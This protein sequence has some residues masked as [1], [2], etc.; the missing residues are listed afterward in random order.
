MDHTSGA[1]QTAILRNAIRGYIDDLITNSHIWLAGYW[2]VPDDQNM[3]VVRKLTSIVCSTCQYPSSQNHGLVI[4]FQIPCTSSAAADAQIA[5]VN[6]PTKVLTCL[7]GPTPSRSIAVWVRFAFW[8]SSGALGSHSTVI[9]FDTKKML[10]IV[11]DPYWLVEEPGNYT[12]ALC[13]RQFH[14]AYRNCSVAECSESTTTQCIQSRLEANVHIDE[15]GLCSCL[16]FV[17]LLCCFR[18]HYFN[19]KH[20]AHIIAD[21]IDHQGRHFK[22]NLLIDWWV[23][24]RNTTGDHFRRKVFPT[25]SDGYCRVF[26]TSSGRCCP[27]KVCNAFHNDRCMCWQHLHLVRRVV[28][29]SKKCMAP[30]GQC[31]I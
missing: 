11:F 14:P 23:S 19:P 17:V 28:G 30:F 1:Q 29:H 5:T 6:L 24:L 18:F 7:Q 10:Q 16:T 26:G 31:P 8:D 4:N 13:R 9:I 27:R 22:A 25:P 21:Y 15:R 2:L 3:A 12:S 20:I